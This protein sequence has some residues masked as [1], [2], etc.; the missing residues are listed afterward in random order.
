MA[1]GAKPA[2][3]S[4]PPAEALPFAR[5]SEFASGYLPQRVFFSYF[6]CRN[7]D[8]LYCRRF[9]TQDQ[10]Q[11]LYGR[12]AENMG[13][14]PLPARRR[15]Q[16]AYAR[17]MMK[18]VRGRGG[19]LEI[20]PDIG[21][22]AECCAA[23]G[24]FDRLWLY[25]PNQSVHSELAERLARYPHRVHGAM[26]PTPDVP[27]GSVSAA[28]LI[29]VLDH[30]LEPAAF[31]AQIRDK[32]EDDGVL[33]VVTH[34]AA[35]LLARLLGRRFPPFAL[36]HPQLYS[37]RSLRRLMESSG[38]AVVEIGGAVNYFPVMHLVRAVATILGGRHFAT[39]AQGPTVPVRL[40]NMAVVARK[41]AS[42]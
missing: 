3:A 24:N 28:A 27:A 16:Q 29:H 5:H 42:R 8:A 40:G 37:P 10:L 39:A 32:L 23:A 22:F 21:L 17:R 7:C 14:V 15:T 25:E 11:S 4:D 6:R 33:F 9:Y 41:C 26:T 2:V 1:S 12:Q 13:D 31:L 20:G 19:F 38:F 36:Q 34:N 35:S 18:H 30:L